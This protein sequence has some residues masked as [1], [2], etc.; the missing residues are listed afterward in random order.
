MMKVSRMWNARVSLVQV[1]V[2]AINPSPGT[3]VHAF[4]RNE[5]VGRYHVVVLNAIDISAYLRGVMGTYIQV[6]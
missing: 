4:N 3:D 6:N 1:Q 2:Q 5:S